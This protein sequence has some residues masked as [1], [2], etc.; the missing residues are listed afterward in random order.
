MKFNRK[1]LIACI[2]IALLIPA[3]FYL[4]FYLTDDNRPLHNITI[5]FLYS[6]IVSVSIFTVNIKIV[7]WLQR[8]FPWDKKLIQRLGSEILLTNFNAVI[9][10]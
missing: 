7:N 9:I 2:V 6:F 1:I 3:Y 5:G 8:I 4:K 10:V